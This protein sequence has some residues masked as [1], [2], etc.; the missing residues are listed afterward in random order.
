MGQKKHVQLT[1][2][3][4]LILFVSMA[5]YTSINN[6]LSKHPVIQHKNHKYQAPNIK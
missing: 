1:A 4:I 5:F 2:Y 6:I 3:F